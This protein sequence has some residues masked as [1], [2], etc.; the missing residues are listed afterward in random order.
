MGATESAPGA[1]TS[2]SDKIYAMVAS[3]RARGIPIDGVGLQMHISVDGYPSADAVAANIQR[4][5]ALGLDVHIT[6]VREGAWCHW[7]PD[8]AY[9]P[10]PSL[11]RWTSRASPPAAPTASRCRHR[12]TATSSV[13]ASASPPARAS[14]RGASLTWLVVLLHGPCWPP[15]SSP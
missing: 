6:E 7:Q 4:L 9:A 2:K 8:S 15:Q 1:A 3:M 11:F 12:S 5:G 14:R 13:P 10:S